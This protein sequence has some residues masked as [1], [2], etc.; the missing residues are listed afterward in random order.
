ME[1]AP[2]SILT[3][4]FG[5]KPAG[6]KPPGANALFANTPDDAE[7]GGQ[8]FFSFIEGLLKA[9]PESGDDTANPLGAQAPLAGASFSLD[10]TPGNDAASSAVGGPLALTEEGVLAP[11]LI[12]HPE[13]SADAFAAANAPAGQA[14]GPAEARTAPQLLALALTKDG[15]QAA[16][17]EDHPAVNNNGVETAAGK[18]GTEAQTA[19]LNAGTQAQDKSPITPGLANAAEAAKA[20]TDSAEEPAA[21]I[22]PSVETQKGKSDKPPAH[23]SFS[24]QN[25]KTPGLAANPHANAAAAIAEHAAPE[26]LSHSAVTRDEGGPEFDRLASTRLETV[27]TASDR[28]AHLNPVRDQIVAAV[29]S[30]HGDNRLEVRLDP[31][32]LGRVTIH[33]D[34]DGAEMVRAVISADTPD[35]L[36]LMRR[37][38]DVFQRALE[39]Q[40]FAGLDL[41]F[42]DHGPQE[43]M[44][45]GAQDQLHHFRLAEEETAEITAG[46]SSQVALGR[47]DRRL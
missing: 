5:G 23:M 28:P 43:D 19:I 18:A 42:T 17:G 1:N 29:A 21:E 35:T 38:A 20:G 34:R 47:L 30:R 11:A 6:D 7:K 26:A 41:H 24:E 2:L 27:S 22:D 44:G 45:D 33:F 12:P 31:P 9:A 8:G 37:H 13:V 16:P 25:L 14:G 3:A 39:D 36:D 46:P 15:G 40:G 4:L 32:E 10:F